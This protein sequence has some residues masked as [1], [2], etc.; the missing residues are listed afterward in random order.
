MCLEH[1]NTLD[2]YRVFLY[3]YLHL[4][5]L[6]MMDLNSSYIILL[7]VSFCALMTVNWIVQID[8]TCP[9]GINRSAEC[10]EIS[11]GTT[12]SNEKF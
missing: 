3:D 9:R 1:E 5:Y 7:P 10:L 2:F 12:I 8:E 6:L 4:L 11:L